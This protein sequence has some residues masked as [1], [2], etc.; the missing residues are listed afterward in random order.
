MKIFFNRLDKVNY[1]HHFKSDLGLEYTAKFVL[2]EFK[3]YY[4]PNVI[5]FSYDKNR[6]PIPNNACVIGYRVFI[7]IM[8]K[9][10]NLR[11]LWVTNSS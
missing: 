5:D 7:F 6:Y 9:I 10:Y 8:S 11:C 4:T 3:G 1:K 2:H